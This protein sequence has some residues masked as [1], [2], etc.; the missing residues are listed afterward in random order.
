MGLEHSQRC[1]QLAGLPSRP[2]PCS[3]YFSKGIY[4][5]GIVEFKRT[6]RLNTLDASNPDRLVVERLQEYHEE[7]LERYGDETSEWQKKTGKVVL[8]ALVCRNPD[9]SGPEYVT[10]TGMNYELSQSTGSRCAEQCAIGAA[11]SSFV[12]LRN[13]RSIAVVDPVGPKN[14]LAPCGVCTEM[15]QKIQRESQDFR[16]IEFPEFEN[17]GFN[18]ITS[19]FPGRLTSVY[20]P[21]VTP[22]ELQIWKCVF[23]GFDENTP[24]ATRCMNCKQDTR[25]LGM[26][27]VSQGTKAVLK[28]L[29]GMT[30]TCPSTHCEYVQLDVTACHN[31]L[32]E[33]QR[34]NLVRILSHDLP[35]TRQKKEAGLLKKFEFEPEK[36][37]DLLLQV[38]DQTQQKIQRSLK[39]YHRKQLRTWHQR[40]GLGGIFKQVKV[41]A[42]GQ[43]RQEYAFTELG[44]RYVERLMIM[45]D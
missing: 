42:P 7:Y 37:A 45:E 12:S 40:Q 1:A 30:V 15:L 19:W 22:K 25:S 32:D 26:L 34:R 3:R 41:G 24:L 43:E 6:Q 4:Y 16:V 29:L 20:E 36:F 14:P 38:S 8:A 27:G 33:Q 13:M 2:E 9:S 31:L 28:S 10:F 23:C 17:D 11:V 5:T 35:K 44:K 18:V 21:D 39:R